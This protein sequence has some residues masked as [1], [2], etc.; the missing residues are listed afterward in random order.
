MANP[1]ASITIMVPILVLCIVLMSVSK[2]VGEASRMDASFEDQP[3]VETEILE[4]SMQEGALKLADRV[5]INGF[6]TGSLQVFLGG[7]FGAVCSNRFDP[8]DAAVAC[9]QLGYR[10]GTVLP[11][12]FIGSSSLPLADADRAPFVLENLNCNGTESRLLECPGFMGEAVQDY[13]Y[14]PLLAICDPAG[15]APAFVACGTLNAADGGAVRLTGGEAS[16]D[17]TS[18]FGFL[19]IFGDGGWGSVC[20]RTGLAPTR[21]RNPAIFSEAAATVA[22]RQLG[23]T[24]GV[25]TGIPGTAAA[26]QRRIPVLLAGAECTGEEEGIADCPGPGLGLQTTPC[27]ATEGVA[28][29]CFNRVS[30]QSEEGSLRM[31]GGEER[32]SFAYGRLEIFVRG[33]WSSVCDAAGFT[34]DAAQVACRAVGYDGGASLEFRQPFSGGGVNHVLAADI[35]V[36]IATVDCNGTE[37]SLLQCTSSLD[38]ARACVVPQSNFTDA[39]VL[40]CANSTTAADCMEGMLPEEGA[41]RLRGG[42]GTMCDPI[43][44]G[45]VEVF[46]NGEWGTICVGN[47][48]DNNLNSVDDFLAADVICRQLGFPHGTVMDIQSKNPVPPPV[49]AFDPFGKAEPILQREEVTEPFGRVWLDDVVCHGPEDDVLECYLGDGFLDDAF[50]CKDR[51]D[52]RVRFAVACR[53]FP[54]GAAQEGVAA[55][56]AEEGDVRLVAQST[57][58]NWQLGRP[59]IY[60]EGSWSQIC[61]ASFGAP[62]AVVVCRQLGYSTG[63]AN[64]FQAGSFAPTDGTLVFSEVAVTAPGCNGAEANL[65][66]C[67]PDPNTDIRQTTVT[68]AS[69]ECLGAS[70]GLRIACVGDPAEGEEGDLRLI[71]PTGS[72]DLEAPGTGVMEIFHAGAWGTICGDLPAR[73]STLGAFENGA[74]DVACRQLGFEGG[75]SREITARGA[76]PDTYNV[77]P[78]WLPSSSIVC[79]GME[80]TLAEC[81]PVR[82]GDTSMCRNTHQLVCS[83]GSLTPSA[84]RGAARLQDGQSDPDGAWAYGR[85]EVFD[86]H[87]FSRIA[88]SRDGLQERFLDPSVAQ[89]VCRSLGYT[90]GAELVAGRFSLLPLNTNDPRSFDTTIGNIECDGDE[91]SLADCELTPTGVFEVGDRRDYMDTFLFCSTPSGCSDATAAPSEGDIRLVDIAENNAS[92]STASCDLAHFG[93]VEIFHDGKWGRVCAGRFGH[94]SASF[95]IASQVICRQLGFAF[96]GVYQTDGASS[97]RVEYN[98]YGIDDALYTVWATEVDCRGDEERLDECFLPERFGEVDPR[99][100]DYFFYGG[101]REDPNVTGVSVT[102]CRLVSRSALGVF[103]RQVEIKESDVIRRL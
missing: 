45:F 79:N 84:N 74:A 58:R 89:V 18:R 60:F 33:F 12:E 87:A 83:G 92:I 34:P 2:C 103:C 17:G 15:S 80:L 5:N 48:R 24:G 57:V 101:Y 98:E 26:A 37:T 49:L 78:P 82:F 41:V 13:S 10:G 40:A 31:M 93:G 9:R 8:V 67:G 75:F 91:D 39:T 29:H 28:V 4:E 77:A 50:T 38:Q 25:K 86:G 68:I 35:P 55:P 76:F 100:E 6:V 27:S 65:L 47:E 32:E 14:E 73:R 88:T 61:A 11:D 99:D 23:F 70:A 42:F 71:S 44:T 95:A 52:P 63:T 1:S 72:S 97:A 19:E 90:G 53:Q 3:V 16:S 7:A 51:N 56:G 36:G 54:V 59:E 85:L 64:S 102:S 22:C 46:H 66:E 69:R 94:S 20:D 81:G 21:S 30:S 43:H 62:D 96:G